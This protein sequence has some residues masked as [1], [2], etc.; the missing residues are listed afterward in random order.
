MEGIGSGPDIGD[1]PVGRCPKSVAHFHKIVNDRFFVRLLKKLYRIPRFIVYFKKAIVPGRDIAIPANILKDGVYIFKTRD[2]FKGI[3]YGVK[4]FQLSREGNDPDLAFPV[5]I[6][7]SE[8]AVGVPGYVL[9]LFIIVFIVSAIV[10]V[11]PVLGSEPKKSSGILCYTDYA[12]LRQ[13]VVDGN[14]LK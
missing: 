13:P 11:Q 1:T 2:G 3:G 14:I 9:K 4:F 6:H 7:F 10:F 12:I 5:A 8:M